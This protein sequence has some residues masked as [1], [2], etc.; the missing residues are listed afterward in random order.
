MGF[1]RGLLCV[2]GK[3][4]P[5]EIEWEKVAR[6]TDGRI[7]AWGDHRDENRFSGRTASNRG[8]VAVGGS[9]PETALME[10]AIWLAMSGR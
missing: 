4:L 1:G 6:G 3:R 5:T 10:L 7:W 9:L 2:G 8:P